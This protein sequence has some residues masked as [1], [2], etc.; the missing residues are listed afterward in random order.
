MNLGLSCDGSGHIQYEFINGNKITG[1]DKWFS[2]AIKD[3]WDVS[4]VLCKSIS[5]WVYEKK[6][7]NQ[8]KNTTNQRV[9]EG[10]ICLSTKTTYIYGIF[11]TM[12]F[13]NTPKTTYSLYVWIQ[14]VWG[15]GSRIRIP[16][17]GMKTIAD[18]PRLWNWSPEWQTP[19]IPYPA[20]PKLAGLRYGRVNDDKPKF[21]NL[22]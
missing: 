18:L 17:Y 22:L 15:T 21:P 2:K 19:R 10:G 14:R 1:E 8:K 5:D 9:S 4:H 13:Q 7:E 6:P 11:E 16:C 20:V 3:L 12:I